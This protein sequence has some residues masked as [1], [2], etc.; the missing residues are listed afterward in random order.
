MTQIKSMSKAIALSLALLI[1]SANLM[2]SNPSDEERLVQGLSTLF[3]GIAPEQP[4]YRVFEEITARWTS[5]DHT[6]TFSLREAARLKTLL[7]HP[8]RGPQADQRV[9]EILFR[10]GFNWHVYN[11]LI[12]LIFGEVYDVATLYSSVIGR[13]A[14]GVP[15]YAIFEKDSGFATDITNQLVIAYNTEIYNLVLEINAYLDDV[16]QRSPRND[17]VSSWFVNRSQ[18]VRRIIAVFEK[19][20]SLLTQ[21]QGLLATIEFKRNLY[22]ETEPTK[23]TALLELQAKIEDEN[24]EIF[25]KF[26]ALITNAKRRRPEN[27]Y[28]WRSLDQ[29]STEMRITPSSLQKQFESRGRNIIAQIDEIEGTRSAENRYENDTPYELSLTRQE[30]QS[31]LANLRN[32]WQQ[33]KNFTYFKR[34]DTWEYTHQRKSGQLQPFI[35]VTRETRRRRVDFTRIPP[36]LQESDVVE[37]LFEI[38][39]MSIEDRKTVTVIDDLIQFVNRSSESHQ[40]YMRQPPSQ[41]HDSTIHFQ[42]RNSLIKRLH[43]FALETLYR[44]RA[45]AMMGYVGVSFAEDHAS[46]YRDI[47]KELQRKNLITRSL[48]GLAGGLGA[49]GGVAA[50]QCWDLLEPLLDPSI[51][52]LPWF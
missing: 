5:G 42:Q 46:K 16:L 36:I 43:A 7:D 50:Y 51:Y 21:A 4:L 40:T 10:R 52:G 26:R 37:R 24:K 35:T 15:P 39:K 6:G 18:R 9:R 2:A 28:S 38:G 31:L 12:T 17:R 29:T 34:N 32:E 49:A 11:Q 30:H 13:Q 22:D 33:I 48:Q 44:Q 47:I 45:E 14:A 19:M 27:P 1:V 8:E 20:E 23:S 41:S 25:S 3:D